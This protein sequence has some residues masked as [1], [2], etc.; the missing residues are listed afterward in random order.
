MTRHVRMCRKKPLGKKK[1][2]NQ[3]II[4]QPITSKNQR[5]KKQAKKGQNQQWTKTQNENHWAETNRLLIK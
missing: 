1:K 4:N 5:V 2:K 3:W